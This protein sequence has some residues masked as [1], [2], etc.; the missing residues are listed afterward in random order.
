MKKI[1]VFI[2][3]ISLLFGS[4]QNLLA[5]EESKFSQEII[6]YGVG[7][8]NITLSFMRSMRYEYGSYSEL[9]SNPASQ[10]FNSYFEYANLAK[11]TQFNIGT[12]ADVHLPLIYLFV[13]KDKSR[14]RVA[15]D[16]GLGFIIGS[17]SVK[18]KDY[19]TGEKLPETT[20]YSAAGG[21]IAFWAGIQTFYRIN[22]TLDV[23]VKFYPYYLYWGLAPEGGTSG[24]GY[25]LHTR[26]KKIYVDLLFVK[27][28][29]S[30][31]LHPNLTY[32]FSIKYLYKKRSFLTINY[33]FNHDSG[34]LSITTSASV[35]PEIAAVKTVPRNWA[36]YQIGWGIL[37]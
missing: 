21:S 8:M 29:N 37:F 4:N 28:K 17:N 7:G 9:N 16:V 18:R 13:C 12:G 33:M 31:F 35:T 30:D 34:H 10:S 19:F 2:F 25:G 27:S 3:C 14:F 5:Q 26:I 23:G 20:T 1:A 11:L 32:N 36:L 6:P 15:D 22:Q 24:T